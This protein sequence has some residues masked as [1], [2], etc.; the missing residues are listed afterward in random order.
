MELDEGVLIVLPLAEAKAFFGFRDDESRLKFIGELLE[1]DA[2]AKSTC[3]GKWQALHDYLSGVEIEQSFLGQAILGG[4]AVHQADNYH[5]MLV[6]PDIVGFVAQQLTQLE[7]NGSE[8]S[9][10]IQHITKVYQQAASQ[11][12]AI[13]FAAKVT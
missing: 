10:L 1:N 6:R 13:V 5:V 8:L 12:G 9:P 3:Q 7:D 2:I 11:R 4:R